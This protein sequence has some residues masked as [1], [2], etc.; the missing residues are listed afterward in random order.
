MQR[1]KCTQFPKKDPHQGSL[2]TVALSGINSFHLLVIVATYF[3]AAMATNL[4]SPLCLDE[5][6]Q[7]DAYFTLTVEIGIMEPMKGKI[8]LEELYKLWKPPHQTPQRNEHIDLNISK[9]NPTFEIGQQSLTRIMQ[10][11]HLNQSIY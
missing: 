3:L 9:N 7:R 4:H 1:W 5:I 6:Q 2:T 10:V 11:T 8:V